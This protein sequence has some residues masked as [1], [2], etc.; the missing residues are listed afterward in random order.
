MPWPGIQG[1]LC[2]GQLLEFGADDVMDTSLFQG[3]QVGLA[4]H[5][6][7]GHTHH[8]LHVVFGLQ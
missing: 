7:V 2:F 4:E 6:P 1:L 3:L 8:L 5:P